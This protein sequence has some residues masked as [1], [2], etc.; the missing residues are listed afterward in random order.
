MFQEMI[1]CLITKVKKNIDHIS[2]GTKHTIFS[3][4]LVLQK[5]S[6][7][8]QMLNDATKIIIEKI[9]AKMSMN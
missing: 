1:E 2:Q 4:I 7:S 9:F 5:P 8:I 6:D 3:Q